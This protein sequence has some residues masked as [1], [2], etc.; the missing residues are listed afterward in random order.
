MM[1]WSCQ[2]MTPFIPLS[3]IHHSTGK[4]EKKPEAAAATTEREIIN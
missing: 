4:D 3:F 2:Q 1:Q